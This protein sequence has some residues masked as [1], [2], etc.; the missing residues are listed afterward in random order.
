MNV[1]D[2]NYWKLKR[3]SVGLI[4]DMHMGE[5]I[6]TMIL[7]SGKQLL[8][9]DCLGELTFLPNRWKLRQKHFSMLVKI[10][11]SSKTNNGKIN[12]RLNLK[13][14]ALNVHF[15]LKGD[16]PERKERGIDVY[17][18][19]LPAGTCGRNEAATIFLK[20]LLL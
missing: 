19:I 5:T 8:P 15:C 10:C 4:I 9:M 12:T 17:S 6:Q 7:A 2:N 14:T 18:L 16:F 20:C 11:F 1:N 13:A 3:P